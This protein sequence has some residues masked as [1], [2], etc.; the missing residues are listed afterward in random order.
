MRL[1]LNILKVVQLKMVWIKAFVRKERK[2]KPLGK[3][4]IYEFGKKFQNKSLKIHYFSREN[5][6]KKYTISMIESLNEIQSSFLKSVLIQA[7]QKVWNKK[8]KV[9]NIFCFFFLEMEEFLI[10]QKIGEIWF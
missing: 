3:F 6:K 4:I 10:Y 7:F 8:V 9:L 2:K 1:N 5:D